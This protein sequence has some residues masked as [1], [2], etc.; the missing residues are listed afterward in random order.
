MTSNRL[1]VLIAEIKNAATAMRSAEKI[2]ADA[3]IVIGRSLV[4]AKGMV[5]HGEWLPFLKQAGIHERTAQRLM[6]LA[7]AIAESNLKSD[8][9]S[10]LGGVTPTL[11]FL[12]LRKQALQA[13]QDWD[14][15]LR[16]GDDGWG[17]AP[18][19]RVLALMDEMVA[20]LPPEYQPT[21]RVNHE[22]D[23]R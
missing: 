1:P 16:D 3:A 15:A 11:R 21:L 12:A 4:E 20:M 6:A 8:I 5:A 10:D 22:E 17:S 14:A 18:A 13:F 9:V 2:A 7:D 23:G 19:A